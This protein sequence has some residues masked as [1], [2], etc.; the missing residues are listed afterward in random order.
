MTTDRAKRY[1]A[2]RNVSD[3]KRAGCLFCGSNQHLTVDH[4]DGFEEHGEPD[5]LAWLCKS[6]NTRKGAAFRKSGIGRPTNQ[7]NP[8][9]GLS[10][11]ERRNAVQLGFDFPP[12]AEYDAA[13]SA[14]RKRKSAERASSIRAKREARAAERR[15]AKAERA[16]EQREIKARI[17]ALGKSLQGAR[18]DGDRAATRALTD[19]INWLQSEVRRRNPASGIVTSDDWARA[20]HASMGGYGVTATRAAARRIRQTSP[21]M[22]RKLA[23]QVQS[24]PAKYPTYAQYCWAVYQ[25]KRGEHDE[26]G[27]VIHATPARLRHEYAD[28][29]ADTKRQKGTNRRSE[30]P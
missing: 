12:R 14:D 27:A 21:G 16:E 10:E 4:L 1:A 17:S 25:H 30:V 13:R 28:R 20:V 8:Y 9:L 7:Y 15:R 6:C 2:N 29:I 18:H 5:N 22:R 23:R 24:N 26:G 11:E 19:E 3:D